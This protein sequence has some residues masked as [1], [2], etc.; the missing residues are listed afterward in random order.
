M[1]KSLNWGKQVTGTDI[2]YRQE[3]ASEGILKLHYYY[4]N[5]KKKEQEPKLNDINNKKTEIV[6]FSPWLTKIL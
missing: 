4:Y 2:N 5:H 6:T 3:K 1:T